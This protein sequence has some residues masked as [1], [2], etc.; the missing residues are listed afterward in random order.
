MPVVA[1]KQ[2]LDQKHVACS[3]HSV[4]KEVAQLAWLRIDLSGILDTVPD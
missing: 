4:Q 2:L 3:A 1:L